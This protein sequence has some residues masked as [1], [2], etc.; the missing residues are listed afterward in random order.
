MN[1]RKR[2]FKVATSVQGKQFRLTLVY[3][4]MMSV[5]EARATAMEVL[6]E[7]RTGRRPGKVAAVAL[8]TLRDALVSYCAAKR[9]KASGQR[10][11]DSS[12]GTNTLIELKT[13]CR[14][15][16]IFYSSIQASRDRERET[17]CPIRF[18][19]NCTL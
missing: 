14:K 12:L 13:I 2:T 11:Y 4:P 17:K 8:P 3:W 9:L 16:L 18:R 6:R 19:G 15:W 5:D 1:P 7:C 10:R